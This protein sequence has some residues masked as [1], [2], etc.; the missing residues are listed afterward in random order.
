MSI[1]I[2]VI[3]CLHS[4]APRIGAHDKSMFNCSAGRLL[5]ECQIR[6]E[7]CS[8]QQ[9][10]ENNSTSYPNLSTSVCRKGKSLLCN[11]NKV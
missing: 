11:L 9:L 8:S 7:K 3:T 5:K 2:G 1:V 4:R 6:A 10:G